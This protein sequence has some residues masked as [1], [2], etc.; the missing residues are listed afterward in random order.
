VGH[1]NEQVIRDWT[2]AVSERDLDA[3]RSLLA[4]SA[5]FHIP[6]NNPIAGDYV[7]RDHVLNDLFRRLNNVFDRLDVELH[8]VLASDEHVVAL[9]DRTA[10]RGNRS[11]QSRAV[12]VYHIRG[13]R[14]VEAWVQETDQQAYDEF[15]SG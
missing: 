13:G 3:A 14:I 10:R 7:G 6:G 4:E 9:I 15:T 12:G 2:R 1:P 11:L 8:D 5:T